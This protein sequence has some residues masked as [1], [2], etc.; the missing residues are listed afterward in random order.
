MDHLMI[1][2]RQ[3]IRIVSVQNKLVKKSDSPVKILTVKYRTLI[4][5][6]TP[7]P[8]QNLTHNVIGIFHTKTLAIIQHLA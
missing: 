4:P 3:K 8:I 1:K 5:I 7:T 2:N 6:V